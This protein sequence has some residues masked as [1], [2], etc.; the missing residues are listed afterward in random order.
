VNHKNQRNFQHAN[1]FA[2]SEI[3]YHGEQD[4]QNKFNQQ[5]LN[6][7]AQNISSP[8]AHKHVVHVPALRLDSKQQNARK[9]K[10]QSKADPDTSYSLTFQNQSPSKIIAESILEKNYSLIPKEIHEQPNTE[11]IR[12]RAIRGHRGSTKG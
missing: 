3:V 4:G 2:F 11:K 7:K 10:V 8:T 12:S 9:F 5:R 6:Q 1:G